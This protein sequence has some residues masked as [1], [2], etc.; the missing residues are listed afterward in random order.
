[1]N[2]WRFGVVLQKGIGIKQVFS[3][4]GK[5]FSGDLQ[6]SEAE[7]EMGRDFDFGDYGAFVWWT[8]PESS[9][10]KWPLKNWLNSSE[11][12]TYCEY[13]LLKDRVWRYNARNIGLMAML[14]RDIMHNVIQRVSYPVISR[15]FLC[16]IFVHL[17]T[18][19]VNYFLGENPW[20]YCEIGWMHLLPSIAGFSSDRVLKYC[21]A[22]DFGQAEKD[23]EQ[24][25]HSTL[26]NRLTAW[27]KAFE[28]STARSRRMKDMIKLHQTYAGA[29][30]SQ[31]VC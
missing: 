14:K 4:S 19:V 13:F 18:P 16:Y 31:D 29:Y 22:E 9:G 3:T 25:I 20:S 24:I 27:Q 26:E 7:L 17:Y 28:F 1:M 6:Y 21:Q 2:A 15:W 5:N 12:L 10:E 30:Y 11:S 23:E 8:S